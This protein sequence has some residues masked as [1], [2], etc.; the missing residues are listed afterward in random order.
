MGQSKFEASQF[1]GATNEEYAKSLKVGDIVHFDI[2]FRSFVRC[3][4]IIHEGH[5]RLKPLAFRGYF[6]AHELPHRDRTGKPV[7][8]I[9]SIIG[10][11][12][13]LFWPYASM[14]F[15]SSGY[16]YHDKNEV[17]PADLPDLD[18]SVPDMTPEQERDAIFYRAID[19][20]RGIFDADP[21]H[22][23]TPTP[24]IQLKRALSV[25][26]TTLKDR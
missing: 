19:K 13:E 17:N 22:P 24:A 23:H 21:T 1:I 16:G 7:I 9:A 5:K 2:N 6:H 4:V 11:N 3:E 12:E 18:L 14:I 10:N 15:E 25:I 26:L 20:I 8:G